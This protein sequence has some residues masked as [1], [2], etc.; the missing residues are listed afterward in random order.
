MNYIIVLIIVY[1]TN[2]ETL[3]IFSLLSSITFFITIILLSVN[4][5]LKPIIS[6]LSAKHDIY[7]IHYHFKISGK[8]IF[9]MTIPIFFIT[10]LFIDIIAIQLKINLPDSKILFLS[11]LFG[12]LINSLKGPVFIT[13]KMMGFIEE[14]KNINIL[15]FISNIL[16]YSYFISNNG[17]IGIGLASVISQILNATLGSVTLYIKT[18]IHLFDKDY[19][20]HIILSILL[21]A[22]IYNPLFLSKNINGDNTATLIRLL[23][24]IIFFLLNIVYLLKKNKRFKI[25]KNIKMYYDN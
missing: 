21:A 11:L 3:G 24:V 25:F 14:V 18:K 19:L 10:I 7:T 17:L 4:S 5:V 1:Y 12:Q 22:S 13:L 20:V 8:I 2:Y 16:I 6:R 9:V 23:F 15:F